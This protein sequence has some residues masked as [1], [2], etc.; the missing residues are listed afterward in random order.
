L[1]NLINDIL[2]VAKI[3]SGQ[4]TLDCNYVSVE[5]LCSSS[6]AFIRQQAS[7]KRVQLATNIQ[8]DLPDLFADEIRIR[9]VLLNLL[10][11]AVK[12]T[13]E[14][15]M[16]TLT[17]S[18][19][20]QEDALQPTY[21]RIQIT[22]TGIGIAPENI[23]KL[24]QPF[25]QIDGALNRQQ[26]GTGLGLALVKQIVELH[27]GQV[28]LTSKLKEGSCFTVDLPYAPQVALASQ[29]K[30]VSGSNEADFS[31]AHASDT[32]P[33]PSSLILLAEDNLANV[34][35]ISSYLEAKGYRLLIASDGQEAIDLAISHHP[36][37]ILMD[38]QMPGVDGLEAMRHIRQQE[39]LRETLIIALTALA[40]TGDRERC[41]AAG[42]DDYLSKPVRLK[43]LDLFIKKL[44]TSRKSR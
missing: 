1:L 12:F 42:A 5:Q 3:A 30:S 41:L 2:D 32:T 19:F 22:D 4:I 9:Q 13:L 33:I 15:G 34:A 23:P 10:T 7:N 14:G 8:P 43:E 36:D 38:V 24:F 16:V 6:L 31:T 40:M 35:T 28:E 11:N 26:T 44:F 17:V 37:V 27:G 29:A 18:H 21:L 39:S 20:S 25:V